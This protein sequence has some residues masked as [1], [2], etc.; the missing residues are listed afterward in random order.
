MSPSTFDWKAH[1]WSGSV[2]PG[3][4][5]LVELLQTLA[6]AHDF[7]IGQVKEKFGTLRVYAQGTD[8]FYDLIDALDNA[9]AHICERCG[10]PGRLRRFGWVITACDAC[11]AATGQTEYQVDP[12][13]GK[14]IIGTPAPEKP[15]EPQNTILKEWQQP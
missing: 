15:T 6:K 7:P 12:V 11:A 10:A 14:R 13:T 4:K 1:D 9:S 8:W 5:P 3:W 2:G